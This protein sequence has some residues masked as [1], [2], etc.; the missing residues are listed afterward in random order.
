MIKASERQLG[1]ILVRVSQIVGRMGLRGKIDSLYRFDQPWSKGGADNGLNGLI[2]L[3]CH[4]ISSNCLH[5]G[6]HFIFNLGKATATVCKGVLKYESPPLQKAPVDSKDANCERTFKRRNN[7]SS[8]W[9]HLQ[10]R[11]DWGPKPEDSRSRN[12]ADDHYL[13]PRV[14]FLVCNREMVWILT[15]SR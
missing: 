3:L 6:I 2:L 12:T 10:L 4:T 8:L 1:W 9:A 15:P 14:M 13:Q 5:R 7:H 11:M